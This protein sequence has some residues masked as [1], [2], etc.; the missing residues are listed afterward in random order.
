MHLMKVR[1]MS[2]QTVRGK[3]LRGFTLIELLVVVA[4]IALLISILLPSLNR[5]RAQARTTLCLTRIAQ[6]VKGFLTYC[7]DYEETPPFM[8]KMNAYSG[9]SGPDPNEDWLASGEEIEVI[10]HAWENEWEGL[11]GRPADIPRSGRLFT[12]TRFENLY[13][14]PDFE[15]IGDPDKSQNV[16]NYTR[17]VWCR[18]WVLPIETGWK[19][20]WGNVKHI[21]KVSQVYNPAEVAMVLDEQWNRH[22]ACAGLV[23]EWGD[24]D[25]WYNCTD[26]GFYPDNVV[27]MSHGTPT[28]GLRPDLDYDDEDP[29]H[30]RYYDPFLWKRGGVA[31]YDGHA[32]LMR[33]PWPTFS[34]GNNPAGGP[35]RM[36]YGQRRAFHE[37]QAIVEFMKNLIFAQRG[38]DPESRY[39]P[40][41][42]F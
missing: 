4:I 21:L 38:F 14:C 18:Y 11:L 28:T 2:R 34:L 17:A 31:Y 26:Y 3:R 12:Y 7:E 20:Y 37:Y 19:D 8:S 15:R 5:A 13:K 29:Y 36:D 6:I 25:S 9:L 27:A 24:N 32:E 42:P 35:F 39:L 40:D 10:H 16:F 33:D 41:P 22:V 1:T 30:F 23:A